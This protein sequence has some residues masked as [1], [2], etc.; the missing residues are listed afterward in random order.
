MTTPKK[1]T[2]A[3]AGKRFTKKAKP[4]EPLYPKG[5]TKEEVKLLCDALDSHIFHGLSDKHYRYEGEVLD[6]GS[7]N[8]FIVEEI[9]AAEAL[10]YKLGGRCGGGR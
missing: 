4:P 3:A 7:D 6:P 9:K 1:K 10:L 8:P 5:F 2:L